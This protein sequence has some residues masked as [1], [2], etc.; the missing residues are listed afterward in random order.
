MSRPFAFA[1]FGP[2]PYICAAAAAAAVYA[3]ASLL[4]CTEGETL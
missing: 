1:L 2:L 4:C 3:A